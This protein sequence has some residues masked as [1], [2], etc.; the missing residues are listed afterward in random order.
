MWAVRRKS[1]HGRYSRTGH[2]AGYSLH[3]SPIRTYKTHVV[4][5]DVLG[6]T[7]T[8]M[9]ILKVVQK[10]NLP[11]ELKDKNKR[12]LKFSYIFFNFMP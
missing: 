12:V 4:W 1:S 10:Q 5:V 11:F 9:P 6:L 8:H 3:S 7:Y 2:V